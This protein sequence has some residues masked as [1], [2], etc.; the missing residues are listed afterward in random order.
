MA[1]SKK[2][3]SLPQGFVVTGGRERR[4]AV[5]DVKKNVTVLATLK[6]PWDK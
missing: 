3:S 4:L 1:G 5:V 6:L 2:K